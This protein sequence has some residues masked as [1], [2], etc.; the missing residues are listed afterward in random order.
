MTRNGSD[1]Q[2]TQR[3]AELE[4]ENHDLVKLIGQTIANKDHEIH[5]LFKEKEEVETSLHEIN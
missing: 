3:V 4:N 1:L 2:L 5:K